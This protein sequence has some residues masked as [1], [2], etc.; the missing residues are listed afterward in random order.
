MFS[1]THGIRQIETSESGITPI[2]GKIYWHLDE[3]HLTNDLTKFQVLFGLEQAF[4]AWQSHMPVTFEATDDLSMAAIVF[5]F[6][7]DGNPALPS[8]FGEDT[9][10][11]AFFPAGQ[12]LG[13]HSDIYMNDLIR[14]ETMHTP[15]GFNLFKVV[16]HEIGHSLGLDHSVIISDIMFPT[17]QPNDEVVLT[18][19]TRDGIERLYGP[20]TAIEEADCVKTFLSAVFRTEKELMKLNER[21]IVEI[22]NHIGIDAK[23]SDMKRDTAQAGGYQVTE[24]ELAKQVAQE[25]VAE[26][27][28]LLFDI[29][30]TDMESRIE[31]KKNLSFMT[32]L[33]RGSGKIGMSVVTAIF[34][35]AGIGIATVI[36]KAIGNGG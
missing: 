22:A 17:Y 14:W 7:V 31:L 16:V 8:P 5:R 6:M 3:S 19:D 26:T 15:N 27:F 20:V 23:L 21:E 36:M 33:R 12:S 30:I 9:L 13:I 4:A 10:A 18:Q 11:Y 24:K 35:M 32:T 1:C 28:N 34:V 29:D 25:V 2:N